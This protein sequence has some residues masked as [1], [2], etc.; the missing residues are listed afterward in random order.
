MDESLF[1]KHLIQIKKQKNSKEEVINY[2]KEKTGIELSGEMINISKKQI[3]FTISSVLKQKLHQNNI[4]KILEEK[5]Y[6]VKSL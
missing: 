3:S 2:I 5:G 4:I 1:V 6:V